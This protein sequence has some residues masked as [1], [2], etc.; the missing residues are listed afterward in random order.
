MAT[1][2]TPKPK[3]APAKAKQSE[4]PESL[5]ATGF[6]RLPKIKKFIGVC[7]ATIWR[8]SKT[9]KFPAPVK[10]SPTITAWRAEDVRHWIEKQ[11]RA[12]SEEA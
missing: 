1:R 7:D 2:I 11:G 6:V 10:L 3:P 4:Q 9:G 8:W 5:P 12:Q